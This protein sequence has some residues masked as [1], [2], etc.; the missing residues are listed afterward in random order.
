MMMSITRTSRSKISTLTTSIGL[1]ISDVA[2]LY[3]AF[4]VLDAT[5]INFMK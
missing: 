1:Y 2:Q 5:K 4:L 3:L